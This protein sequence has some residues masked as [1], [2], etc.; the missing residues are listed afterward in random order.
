[1]SSI[2][3]DQNAEGSKRNK[4]EIQNQKEREKKGIGD[5]KPLLCN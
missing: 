5:L 2:L 3:V 1:M 4:N